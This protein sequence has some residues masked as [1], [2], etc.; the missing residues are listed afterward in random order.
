MYNQIESNP[1][2]KTLISHVLLKTTSISYFKVDNM[3]QL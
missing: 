3:N 1:K 2:H